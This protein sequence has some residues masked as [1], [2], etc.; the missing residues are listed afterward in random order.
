MDYSQDFTIP[1]DLTLENILAVTTQEEIFSLVFGYLP[2]EYT[3]TTSPFREDKTPGCWFEYN[4][5]GQL[6]FKDYANSQTFQHISLRSIDCIDAV[7]VYYRFRTLK[8]T[9]FFIYKNLIHNKNL[10]IS[11]L[12]DNLNI[13]HCSHQNVINKKKFQIFCETRFF[14]EKDKIFWTQFGISSDNLKEDKVFAISNADLLNTRSGNIK[15]FYKD[16]AYVYT[17][18]EN[19][20]KKIYEP[21][22]KD[23][24]FI[25]NCDE[26]DVGGIRFLPS[27]GTHLI[28]TKSYK[29]YRLLKNLG[30]IVCWFQNE[31]M[32]PRIE[33]LQDFC[34]RFE[35]I[36]VFFDNDKAGEKAGIELTR[37]IETIAPNK[38]V[39]NTMIPHPQ[40]KDPSDYRKSR[41]KDSLLKLLHLL[42]LLKYANNTYK[43][44][45]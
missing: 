36:I 44:S 16:I 30:F 17:D 13:N 27:T 38:V 28:I 1:F 32:F 45:S 34:S 29:D 15:V 42:N 11:S 8:E 4:H 20:K 12:K 21:N 3:Y 33:V 25:T 26:N 22:N 6:R 40:F 41:G 37:L 5:L 7:R 14:T 24:K 10:E 23:K 2:S 39:I 35:D 19:G 43:S 18:F 9:L 31:G